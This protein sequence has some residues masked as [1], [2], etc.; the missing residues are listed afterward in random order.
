MI[1]LRRLR[2]LRAVAHYGTVTAAAQALHFTPSAASQQIRQLS[3]ELGVELLEP[4]G[5]RVQL[6]PA[7]RT[8]LGHADAIQARWEQA[9]VELRAERGEP[10]G[11]LRVCGFPVAV[12]TLLAPLAA[13]LHARYPRLRVQVH[14]SQLARDSFNLLFDGD[15]D[16]AVIEAAPDNPPASDPRFVQQPL[17]TDVFD[18]VVPVGHALAGRPRVALAEAAGDDWIVPSPDCTC[19]THIMAACSAAGFTP[20]VTHHAME[21]DSIAALIGHGLGVSL[22]PRLARLAP[23]LPVV[24]VP[25]RGDPSPGRRLLTCVRRG[26]Q[27]HPAVAAGLAGLREAAP[28]AAA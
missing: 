20:T 12:A 23:R 28:A 3:R 24:R 25:L 4:H 11:T 14:E 26:A 5:R 2:V 22:V 10:V 7:A 13:A 19:R 16:L 17:L 27:E 8:L 18:L 15:V 21:W 1:D 9:E 6:T